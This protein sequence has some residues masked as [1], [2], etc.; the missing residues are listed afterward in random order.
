MKAKAQTVFVKV[1]ASLPQG[2]QDSKE[3]TC[4]PLSLRGS[5]DGGLP[6]VV[7]GANEGGVLVGVGARGGGV[8][9][10]VRVIAGGT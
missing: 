1:H 8:L 6:F 3:K 2:A 7:V 9:V 5:E 4:G 10:N